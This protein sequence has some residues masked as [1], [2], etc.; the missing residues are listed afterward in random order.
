MIK[1]LLSDDEISP[2]CIEPRLFEQSYDLWTL[3]NEGSL[4]SDGAHWALKLTGGAINA[5]FRIYKLGLPFTL[6]E[7]P[8]SSWAHLQA[9]LATGTGLIVIDY[10]VIHLK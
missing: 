10:H 5:S 9:V 3:W 4:N 7:P 2:I 8:D 6:A 1:C